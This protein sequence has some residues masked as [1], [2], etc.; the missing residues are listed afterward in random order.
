MPSLPPIHR[1]PN[2]EWKPANPHAKRKA[3]RRD[4]RDRTNDPR[5]KQRWKKLRRHMLMVQPLCADPFAYHAKQGEVKVADE[6][7]HIKGALAFPELAHEPDNIA[8]LCHGCHKCVTAIERR[9]DYAKAERLFKGYKW[10]G[11][12]PSLATGGGGT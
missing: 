6:L 3:R 5:V 9:G 7:H 2:H 4:N 12:E 1:V 10:K 8:P 11:G